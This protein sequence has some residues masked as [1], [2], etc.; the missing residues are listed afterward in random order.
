MNKAHFT[1][2]NS[3]SDWI[4][5]GVSGVTCGGKTTLANR[6]KNSLS[7]VYIFHQDKYFYPDDSPKHQK[8]HGLEHNNYD[9]ISSLDMDAM[10]KDVLATIEGDHRFHSHSEEKEGRFEIKGKKFLVVEGFT[11]LNYKPIVELCDLRLVSVH[12]TR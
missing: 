5:I 6:L 1:M 12:Y 9:T 7:P 8:C 11:V 2:V 10:H 3:R 4:V